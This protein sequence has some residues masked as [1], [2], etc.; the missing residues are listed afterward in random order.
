MLRNISE[1][2]GKIQPNLKKKSAVHSMYVGNVVRMC[3]IVKI[4]TQNVN[5][6]GSVQLVSVMFMR[7]QLLSFCNAL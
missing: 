4:Q 5:I 2:V 1:T 3:L 6:S 7:L